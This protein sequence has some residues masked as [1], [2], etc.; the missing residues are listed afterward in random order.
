[1]AIPGIVVLE[2]SQSTIVR[3]DSIIDKVYLVGMSTG[4]SS[5]DL[6]NPVAIKDLSDFQTRFT[7]VADVITAS[8]RL[9][10]RNYSEGNL[11]FVAAKSDDVAVLAGDRSNIIFSLQK[12]ADRDDL[13]VGI[14][15]IPEMSSYPL[16]ADRTAIFSTG[17][18]LVEKHDWLFFTNTATVSDTLPEA[19]A[20]RRL[21][22]SS[23]GHSAIYHGM[24]IDPEDKQVPISVAAATIAIKRSKNESPFAPPA[25]VLYPINGIKDVSPYINKNADF[26]TL[27]NENINLIKFIPKRGWCLWTARTLSN[28]TRFTQIN[29]RMANSITSIRIKEVLLPFLFSSID[30][31]G[32]IKNQVIMSIISVLEDIFISGGLSGETSETAYKVQQ[33]IVSETTALRKI[34]IRAFA[35]FVDTLERVEIAL[36]NVDILP[37]DTEPVTSAEL[38][39]TGIT[40]PTI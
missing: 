27:F 15:I 40:E 33:T 24:I 13:S 19:I 14:L 18:G 35:R 31:R 22:A 11:F 30:P 20:E 37:T 16:Q 25:G 3:D 4:A 6:N 21:Y 29:T 34:Q 17:N 23:Y 2:Q 36:I 7:G 26:E 39:N 32:F 9:F 12:L 8:V 10:F 38:V 5:E 28:D 1:M